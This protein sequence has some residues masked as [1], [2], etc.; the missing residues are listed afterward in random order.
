MARVRKPQPTLENL[1]FAT[2]EQRVMRFLLSEPTAALTPRVI[3]S[4]LKGV[5]GLGGVDGIM[6]ILI[7]LEEIGL[8]DFVDNR[9][10]VRLN[11][12]TSAVRLLK[13]L[14]A[15]CDLEGLKKQLQGVSIKGILFGSRATGESRSDS[16]YNLAVVARSPEEVR[17]LTDRHPLGK[18]IRLLATTEDELGTLERRE[19]TLHQNLVRGI[20]LWGASW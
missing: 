1:F 4:K 7:Q 13:S 19:P 9:R 6:K 15:L 3:S 18:Q 10:A 14:T 11:D 5:R 8:V 2:P 17:K 12:G 16:D 20:V